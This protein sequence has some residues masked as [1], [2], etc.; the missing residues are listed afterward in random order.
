MLK[1]IFSQKWL[2][3]AFAVLLGLYYG[4]L[5][6]WGDDWSW[7]A[8]HK[9]L[10]S[11]IYSILMGLT[12]LSVSLRAYYDWQDTK[13]KAA[14]DKL[15]NQFILFIKD[16]VQAKRT[17]F[18]DKV[19]K[20]ETGKRVNF[21]EV[22]THPKEQLRTIMQHAVNFFEFYGVPRSNLQITILSSNSFSNHWKYE[23]T[24]DRQK[25]HTDANIVM[26]SRSVAN[27][28]L[29][30]GEPIFLAD[31][32]EEG[33]DESQKIFYKSERSVTVNCI[34]SIYCKPVTIIIQEI[35]YNYVFTLVTYG[36]YLCSPNNVEEANQI[37]TLLDEIG[38]RVELELYLLAMRQ[39]Q[40]K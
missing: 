4:T 35:T 12:I 21:F 20:L 26:N 31:L 22:I 13:N 38:D 2:S 30:T 11:K 28:A 25:N 18:Y 23:E 1:S 33:T 8:G 16:I 15:L 34:G 27:K 37:A 40:A 14:Y 24:L 6:I 17:R 9:P 29:Q 19:T 10:H 39:H 36:T 32:S 5:D 3:S 7:I